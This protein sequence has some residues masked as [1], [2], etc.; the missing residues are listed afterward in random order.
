[1][2]IGLPKEIK[3][4][5]YRVGLTPAGVRA[6]SDAKHKVVVE[7]SAGEGSGFEDELYE[8]AGAT[9][10]ESPDDVWAQGEMIIK[11]KEPIAPEYPRMREGQVLFTYLHLAPD[12]ELTKQLLERKVTGV[13]Y[14]TITDR[15]G[16]LPLLTPMS[17]VAGRMAIQVGATYLEK[18]N[19][20]RGILL[21]GVPGVPAARVVI[22]GGGVVGT[23]AAKIAVG[24]GAQ[25][26]IIDNNL[27]R[28]RELD[29]IFLSKV[30]TLA[31]SAYMIHDA[32][33][34]A[35]LIVGA[36]L[37]P[38][39]AAPKLVT[40]A[41]LKDVPKGAVLVDV[42]VDQGGCI[43]TTHPTT[44]SNPTYYVEDV[45]HYCVANMPGAVPRTSTFALTNATLPYALKLANKGFIDAISRDPGLKAGVNTYAGKLTY[46]AVAIAQGLDYTPLD[47][48]LGSTSV[49]NA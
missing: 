8:R 24:M 11:V 3:D 41:M 16:T 27:D 40:R 26:T 12:K 7:K 2:I 18:M 29:D 22:I 4:N 45:L 25:V 28:L 14:E 19:G 9:I 10:L 46:E 21:G 43:E 20:G 32:I 6:L 31:S 23:N 34:Q 44:H 30:S 36:V 42:A 38:G 48:M 1:M 13:A 5:E 17:E 37:V 47:E 49:A 15:R 33:S 35:D 39:A